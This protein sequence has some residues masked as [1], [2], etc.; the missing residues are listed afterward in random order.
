MNLTLN[1]PGYPGLTR[2]I[3]WLLMARLLVS[4]GHQQPSNWLCKLNRSLSYMKKDFNELGHVSVRNVKNC[5]YTFVFLPKNL[6]FRNQTI[7]I[8]NPLFSF[9][10][11]RAIKIHI[12]NA[13]F[14]IMTNCSIYSFNLKVVLHSELTLI[15]CLGLLNS[16]SSGDAIWRHGTR[17]TL[18]Q[19]MTCCLT[20][21]NPYLN[22]CRL[23]ITTVLWHSLDDCFSTCA[24]AINHWN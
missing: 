12:C 5:I 8:Q 18:A 2:S 11:N 17:S 19:V 10:I 23:A 3:S 15:S 21:P 13:D 7:N 14:C 1:V 9:Y 6:A 20:A 24:L 16:L 4:S 22:Q